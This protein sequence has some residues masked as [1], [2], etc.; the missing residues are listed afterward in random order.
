MMKSGY[1]VNILKT[2]YRMHPQI[3]AIIGTNF[4]GQKL[5]N[6]EHLVEE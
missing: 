4:Y 1:P 2:Q 6:W 3:S 5:N